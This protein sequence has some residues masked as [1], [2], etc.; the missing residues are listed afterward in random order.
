MGVH[1]GLKEG[2]YEVHP[3]LGVWSVS[4]KRYLNP[5]PRATG[6]IIIT[7]VLASGGRVTSKCAPAHAMIYET[8]HGKTPSGMVVD[9]INRNKTDNRVVNLRFATRSENTLNRD[10]SNNGVGLRRP[11]NQYDLDGNFIKRW[12]SLTE[13]AVS[14]NCS[15]GHICKCCTGERNNHAGFQWEYEESVIEGEDDWR[16]VGG[17]TLYVSNI[18]RIRFKNGRATFGSNSSGY[19]RIFHAKDHYTVH[20]LVCTAFNGEAPSLG[21]VVNHKD[22]NRSN[23]TPSNLEWLTA[24]DNVR[25]SRNKP[26]RQSNLDGTFVADHVSIDKA[27]E[28]SNVTAGVIGTVC[29][30]GIKHGG[31]YMW[32]FIDQTTP[33]TAGPNSIPVKQYT[34]QCVY[35]GE[36]VNA[37]IAAAAVNG[38]S[39]GIRLCCLGT[40][41]SAFGYIWRNADAEAPTVHVDGKPLAAGKKVR[42]ASPNGEIIVFSSIRKAALSLNDV[43]HGA[44]RW[45]LT[46][47]TGLFEGH[48]WAFVE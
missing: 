18:G 25:H 27:S 34:L 30:G 32:Q 44:L 21:M 9:H 31:G 10:W 26:V 36:F 24:G 47:K 17:T 12:I 14:L 42:R 13:A 39:S 37:D 43:T 23:N 29:R 16:E 33:Y 48:T 22:F 15:D 8:Y 4:R 19:R 11:V 38:S 7:V 20:D 6:Y 28:A 2:L 45:F 40:T 1:L 3:E 5:K 41:H 35:K 46:S